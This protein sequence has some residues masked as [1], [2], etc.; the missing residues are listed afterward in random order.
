[1]IIVAVISD[2]KT[3]KIKNLIVIFFIITGLLTNLLLDG[4]PSLSSSILA[5]IIPV[6]LLIVLFA[7]KMLGAG[8]IKLFCTI[9]AIT[10]MNFNLY[11]MAYSFIAGGIIALVIML[12][13]KSF[14]KR[15]RYLLNYI[16]SCFLTGALLPYSDF[17]NKDDGSVFRFSYAIACGVA[18]TILKLYESAS[19]S[20]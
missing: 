4:L 5:T 3:Y 18:I 9:G 7:L 15:G 6:P 13:G 20:P 2:V 19:V 14:R 17:I 10:G 1:M 8:D 16:K 11:C 12:L